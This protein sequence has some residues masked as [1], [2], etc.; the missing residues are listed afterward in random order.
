MGGVVQLVLD[1]LCGVWVS[2]LKT[3][4][5][6]GQNG[7]NFLK[8]LRPLMSVRL[9]NRGLSGR[10]KCAWDGDSN[11][12]ERNVRAHIRHQQAQQ[13]LRV[14]TRPADAITKPDSC[15]ASF[16]GQPKRALLQAGSGGIR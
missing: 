5:L 16:S 8:R 7:C 13:V 4:E 15:S 3:S 10:L 12:L 6:G 2:G 9:G 14:D 1:G 11:G